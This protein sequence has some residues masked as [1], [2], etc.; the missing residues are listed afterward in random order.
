L[1]GA[2]TGFTVTSAGEYLCLQPQI[3]IAGT[4]SGAYAYAE[5][6]INGTLSS[7]NYDSIM[8]RINGPIE[9]DD[10]GH[11]DFPGGNN[12]YTSA[13]RVVPCPVIAARRYLASTR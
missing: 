11:Y 12:F 8:I 7:I 3:S 5:V 6:A 2:I 10:I 13:S 4:G 9:G 1:G